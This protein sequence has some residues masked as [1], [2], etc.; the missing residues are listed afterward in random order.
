MNEPEKTGEPSMEEILASIRKIIAEEPPGARPGPDGRAVNPLLA[1]TKQR[2]ERP[3][4]APLP[5]NDRP[6]P[7]PDRLSAA[8]RANTLATPSKASVSTRASSFEDDLGDLLDEPAGG[9]PS[10]PNG[11]GLESP[12]AAFNGLSNSQG[13]RAAS[14]EIQQ[15]SSPEP[16]R[17]QK[18]AS[19]A[20]DPAVTPVAAP[21]LQRPSGMPPLRKTGFY[22][23][24]GF[25]PAPESRAAVAMPRTEVVV[26]AIV[27]AIDG[28]DPAGSATRAAGDTDQPGGAPRDARPSPGPSSH[29]S[30]AP[31]ASAQPLNSLPQADAS[32]P[33]AE[34]APETR[35]L[36]PVEPVAVHARA[37]VAR[38]SFGDRLAFVPR[39]E[40]AGSGLPPRA[41]VQPAVAPP[42]FEPWQQ[43]RQSAPHPGMMP[44]AKRTGYEAQSRTEATAHLA[45]AID[46]TA[47]PVG[48]PNGRYGGANHDDLSAARLS[49]LDA[50]ALGLAASS[51]PSRAVPRP[52]ANVPSVG[53]L[54]AQPLLPAINDYHGQVVRTLE[55]AVAEMLKPM[56]QKWL[57]DN[58][59]R[60]IERAL[61]VE[62]A[63]G[64]NSHSKPP[65]S[66]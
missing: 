57:T 44:G 47:E 41:E 18:P 38:P 21:A 8:L 32:A 46:A 35:P 37:P 61:R 62:A 45:W 39:A 49:P 54:V 23:P 48:A 9:R 29:A 66:R 17:D 28:P 52:T 40:E 15:T 26:E 24:K 36:P 12:S 6:L 5:F 65:G 64:I 3:A 63:S 22:P 19:A 60:I 25:A 50:L 10:S 56:L 4:G 58:M 34:P 43:Q 31:E 2:S 14:K 7:S 42:Y 11:F 27:A 1:A 51:E 59:P 13:D 20:E 16:S 33:F 53:A 30:E 55:D